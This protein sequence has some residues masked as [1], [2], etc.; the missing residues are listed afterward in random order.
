M[1]RQVLTDLT[2]FLA[3]HVA[4][5]LVIASIISANMSMADSNVGAGAIFPN[6]TTSDF[7]NELVTQ[8]IEH[9]SSL[10][11]HGDNQDMIQYNAS[12]SIFNFTTNTSSTLSTDGTFI[13]GNQKADG[14]TYNITVIYFD[15]GMKIIPIDPIGTVFTTSALYFISDG[16]GDGSRLHTFKNEG[17]FRIETYYMV[18]VYKPGE[19]IDGQNPKPPNVMG[20]QDYGVNIGN[21]ECE[22]ELLEP[23]PSPSASPSFQPTMSSSTSFN[24]YPQY[25]IAMV[26]VLSTYIIF[27]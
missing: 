17:R 23:T 9:H 11:C 27:L 26:V 8:S 18:T 12:F 16:S 3:S 10:S 2:K 25:V 19:V 1:K 24:S 15:F 22:L 7:S 6:T 13:I 4:S 21:Q 5:L 20:M 14:V